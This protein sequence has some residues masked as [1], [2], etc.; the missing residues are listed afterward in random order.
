MYCEIKS[1]RRAHP[2]RIADLSELMRYLL[3]CKNDDPEVENFELRLAGP[4]VASRLI[5]RINPYENTIDE[6]AY[7]IAA[8]IFNHA[9]DCEFLDELPYEIYKHV[10]ISFPAKQV[11]DKFKKI[12][13]TAV[14]QPKSNFY[15]LVKIV[16]EL[17]DA[18]G[19]SDSAPSY[20][21]FHADTDHTH[22]H[23][24][25]GMYARSFDCSKTFKEIKIKAIKE[26]AATLYAAH[27]W[28]FPNSTLRDYYNE[29]NPT[30]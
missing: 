16:K 19:I 9:Q 23:I 21:V 17:L 10:I 13:S 15:K 5:Q 1:Y 6:A 26:I 14:D 12:S 7:D 3:T 8:Q 11:N 2:Q 27:N 24:V 22:A 30:S 18:M 4:P 20:I 29:L 25:V 28:E